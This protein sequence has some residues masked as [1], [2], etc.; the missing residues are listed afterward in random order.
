ML[1]LGGFLGVF[2]SKFLDAFRL[3][4]FKAETKYISSSILCI[5]VILYSLIS[6]VYGGRPPL[7]VPHWMK[8]IGTHSLKAMDGLRT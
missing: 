5:A 6:N 4:S 8:H 2:F 7:P 1:S 3:V